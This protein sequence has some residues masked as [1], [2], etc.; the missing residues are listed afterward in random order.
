MI[1][2]LRGIESL[3]Y[4]GILSVISVSQGGQNIFFMLDG[5]VPTIIVSALIAYVF[6]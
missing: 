5:I 6:S 2:G 4:S 1:F 3:F